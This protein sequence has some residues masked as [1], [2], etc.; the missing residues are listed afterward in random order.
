M[1]TDDRTFERPDGMDGEEVFIYSTRFQSE[2]EIGKT[3]LQADAEALNAVQRHREKVAKEVEP[4]DDPM[5]VS[6][7]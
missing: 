3:F 5:D 4:P 2:R 7:T 1:N 6:H